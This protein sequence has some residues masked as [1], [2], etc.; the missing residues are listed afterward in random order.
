[1]RWMKERMEG[2]LEI[3]FRGIVGPGGKDRKDI[4]ILGRLLECKKEGYEYK[5][6]PKHRHIVMHKFGLEAE[7]KGLSMHG[8]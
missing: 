2:W 4:T 8:K 3:R 1:M 5:A 6:D 7:S